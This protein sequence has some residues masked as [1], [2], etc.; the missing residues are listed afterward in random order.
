MKKI[1]VTAVVGIAL[2]IWFRAGIGRDAEWGAVLKSIRARYPDVRQVP[3][4]SLAMWLQK[5]DSKVVLLDVRTSAEYRVS[6]IRG[7]INIS[8]DA[9]EFPVLDSVPRDARIVAYCSVGYRS[10]EI[11]SALAKKGFTNVA[12]LEGSVFKWANE[13]R[14]LTNGDGRTDEVHPYNALWGRLLDKSHRA[15][16]P[17]EK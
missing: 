2:F 1:I 4:D 10:S 17:D 6:H 14:P 11:A 7:A 12:N 9:T 16:V 5:P 8:P 3:T 13:G 15:S